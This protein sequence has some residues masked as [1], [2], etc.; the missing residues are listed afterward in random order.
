[1]F[2]SPLSSLESLKTL[3]FLLCP[4][5][6]PNIML[7]EPLTDGIST[8]FFD[9]LILPDP[10]G[11]FKNKPAPLTRPAEGLLDGFNQTGRATID[12]FTAFMLVQGDLL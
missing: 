4:E 11:R 1:M 3:S 12:L 10:P 6:G 7:A 8:P 2:N 9:A 5:P